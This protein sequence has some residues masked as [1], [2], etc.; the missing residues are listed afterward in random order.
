MPRHGRTRDRP[1]KPWEDAYE[2]AGNPPQTRPPAVSAHEEEAHQPCR[3][4]SELPPQCT[5]IVSFVGL[6]GGVDVGGG[7][8]VVP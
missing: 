1:P 6:A 4:A 2:P 5:V 3:P 7:V 8:V